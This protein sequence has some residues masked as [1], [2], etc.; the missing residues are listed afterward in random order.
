MEAINQSD[1]LAELWRL[2]REEKQQ[3]MG[4]AVKYLL[5]TTVQLELPL[6]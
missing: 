2:A 5:E 1:F 4:V 3:P 6:Y